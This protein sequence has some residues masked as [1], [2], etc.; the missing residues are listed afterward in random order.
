M[1]A[2]ELSSMKALR[3]KGTRYVNFWEMKTDLEGFIKNVLKLD[4]T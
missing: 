2:L 1:M 4:P 3:I